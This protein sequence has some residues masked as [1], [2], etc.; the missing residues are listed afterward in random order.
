MVA[1]ASVDRGRG[2]LAG[3]GQ[4]FVVDGGSPHRAAVRHWFDGRQYDRFRG[5]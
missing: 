3:I 5:V 1:L 4:G 2:W